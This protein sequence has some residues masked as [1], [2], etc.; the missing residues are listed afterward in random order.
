MQYKELAE[1]WALSAQQGDL[2]RALALLERQIAANLM[3]V[4]NALCTR[5]LEI[6]DDVYVS[7]LYGQSPTEEN[8]AAM[9]AITDI[10]VDFIIAGHGLD[11]DSTCPKEYVLEQFE[12]IERALKAAMAQCGADS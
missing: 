10:C 6:P 9:A 8:R 7:C 11:F 5:K 12:I 1:S 3:A 2:D 4:H